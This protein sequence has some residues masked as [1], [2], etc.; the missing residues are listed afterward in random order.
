ML[1]GEFP[2]SRSQSGGAGLARRGAH[3]SGHIGLCSDVVPAGHTGGGGP[4]VRAEER[5]EGS[6]L[7]ASSRGR[8]IKSYFGIALTS[9]FGGAERDLREEQRAALGPMGLEG[10]SS[11]RAVFGAGR[12][13]GLPAPSGGKGKISQG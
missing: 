11:C 6:P 12:P 4:N 2:G 7:V 1:D 5:A 10:G 8:A 13:G 3:L 9:C